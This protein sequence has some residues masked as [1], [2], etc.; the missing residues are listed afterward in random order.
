MFVCFINESIEGIWQKGLGFTE[1]QSLTFGV[2]DLVAK[3]ELLNVYDS[4]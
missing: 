2:A 4:V 1:S 3:A